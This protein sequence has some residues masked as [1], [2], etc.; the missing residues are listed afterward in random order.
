[1]KHITSK[2]KYL[3]N[4]NK[5]RRL[6]TILPTLRRLLLFLPKVL[7]SDIRSASAC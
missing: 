7:P 5:K 2:A 4:F 1:M 3:Y 6:Q